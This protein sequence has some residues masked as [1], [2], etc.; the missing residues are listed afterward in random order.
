MAGGL[1]HAEI[2]VS[3]MERSL[4]F[5]RDLLGF[6]V[7]GERAGEP[8]VRWLDAGRGLIKLVEVGPTGHTGGWEN[9]N[10][11]RGIR[12]FAM[13]VGDVDAYSERLAAAGVEFTI[14]PR[15]AAGDVRLSFFLDPD[16]A[17]ME[18]VANPPSYDP[19]WSE[20]LALQEW[21]VQPRPDDP[22][23]FEHVAV[24][25]ADLDSS[26]HFYR[27]RYGMEV[28]GQVVLEDDVGFTI[29]FLKAGDAVLEVF[30]FDAET[31]PNPWIDDDKLLGIRA[32]G[33][34]GVGPPELV[35]DPDGVPLL[36]G[37]HA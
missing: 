2:A 18:F 4:V 10:L 1:E 11:Q 12:H 13:K 20:E 17:L 31:S 22:P 15:T 37:Q 16:G 7:A 24:T 27:E 19:V 28:V 3:D 32:V 25:V 36:V 26:L 8:G 6:Q 23:R 30:S 35:R 33:L 34:G 21:A 29:T 5:Y 9:N 14:T